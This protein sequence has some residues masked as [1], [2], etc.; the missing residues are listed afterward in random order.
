MIKE[1][2]EKEVLRALYAYAEAVNRT[3]AGLMQRQTALEDAIQSEPALYKT[4]TEA[5]ASSTADDLRAMGEMARQIKAL[6]E[7]IVR[8]TK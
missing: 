5:L 6:K 4:Y 1:E 7:V 8:L 3:V 2:E